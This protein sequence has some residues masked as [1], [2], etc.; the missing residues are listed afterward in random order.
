MNKT[1]NVLVG[2]RDVQTLHEVTDGCPERSAVF[3]EYLRPHGIEQEAAVAL[4][5]NTG[6]AWGTLRLNRSPGKP[7]SPSAS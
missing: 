1:S 6:E 5:A 7:G 4:R 3:R 2:E